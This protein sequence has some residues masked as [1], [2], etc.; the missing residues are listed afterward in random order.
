MTI[1]IQNI[2]NA[3]KNVNRLGGAQLTILPNDFIKFEC[4]SIEEC[5]FWEK[6]NSRND[7]LDSGVII[8]TDTNIIRRLIKLKNNGL[9]DKYYGVR[10]VSEPIAETISDP[11]ALSVESE[12]VSESISD[13]VESVS[14]DCNITDTVIDATVESNTIETIATA[15]DETATVAEDLVNDTPLSNE[16][17]EYTEE[18]LNSLSKSELQAILDTKGITYKKNYSEHRLISLILEKQ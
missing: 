16:S 6:L 14:A 12:V 3:V 7:A 13:I 5:V 2:T 8:I 18:Y 15:Q 1:V 10:V 17:S 9:Y 4:D 11:V